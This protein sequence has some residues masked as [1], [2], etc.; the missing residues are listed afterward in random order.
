MV[1]PVP[2]LPE[3]ALVGGTADVRV[4]SRRVDTPRFRGK[5][6]TVSLIGR[7]MCG[8]LYNWLCTEDKG[9][10][11]TAPTPLVGRANR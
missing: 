3:C 1:V 9:L 5:K 10:E 8:D 4:R 11:F 6:Q 2:Y 7:N